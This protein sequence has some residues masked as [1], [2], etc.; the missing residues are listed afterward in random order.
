MREAESQREVALPL[1]LKT[2]NHEPRNVALPAAK[3][4]GKESPLA[5][6]EGARPY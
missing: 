6:P 2:K 4:K 5:L 3:S 1:V